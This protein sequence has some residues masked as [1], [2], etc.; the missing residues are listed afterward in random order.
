MKFF[1][2]KNTI[3]KLTF[4]DFFVG[5]RFVLFFEKDS[6]QGLRHFVPDPA[7]R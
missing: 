4:V 7:L 3:K 5:Q 6:P 2:F 1:K